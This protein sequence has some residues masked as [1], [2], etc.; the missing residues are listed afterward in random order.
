MIHQ[1]YK[2]AIQKA[3]DKAVEEYEIKMKTMEGT[4]SQKNNELMTVRGK[5]TEA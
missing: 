2:E 4:L 1:E 3:K 5:L